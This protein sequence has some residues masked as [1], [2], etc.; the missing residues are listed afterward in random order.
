MKN[1][2]VILLL[3]LTLSGQGQNFEGTITW[4]A[5]YIPLDTMGQQLLREHSPKTFVL[6]A[7][8]NDNFLRADGGIRSSA[9]LWLG[10][11]K[12]YYRLDQSA[13]TYKVLE[14]GD[15]ATAAARPSVTSTG[16]EAVIH[17]YH[18]RKYVVTSAVDSRL[19]RAVYWTTTELKGLDMKTMPTPGTGGNISQTL[20]HEY[21]SGIPLRID[22]FTPQLHTEIKVVSIT[23]EKLSTGDFEIPS[24]F[25]EE[26]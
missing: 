7:K 9:I 20:F 19:F 26:K 8:G 21:V 25:K 11:R 2:L 24:E 15:W 1:I 3:M 10:G 14:N 16:E 12:R 17:G 18:C 23:K 5:R 22:V 4:S 13:R 6:M